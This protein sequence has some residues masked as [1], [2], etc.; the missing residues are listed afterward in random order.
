MIYAITTTYKDNFELLELFNYFYFNKWKFDYIFSLI[1]QTEKDISYLLKD[2]VYIK[3]LFY[4]KLEFKFYKE[5]NHF[6]VIYK[7]LNFTKSN[8]WNSF[9]KKIKNNI[10]NK[11]LQE[12]NKNFFNQYIDND[13]LY[14]FPDNF[15]IKEKILKNKISFHYLE[16]IPKDEFNINDDLLFS[17]Y[18]QSNRS[19][20]MNHTSC[21]TLYKEHFY[22]NNDRIISNNCKNILD[23]NKLDNKFLC[24][25]FSIISKNHFL[26]YRV[27]KYKSDNINKNIGLK[28]LN[29]DFNNKLFPPFCENGRKIF[30]LFNQEPEN[31]TD[32]NFY[33]VC[34][35]Y[36]EYIKNINNYKNYIKINIFKY[37]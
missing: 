16:Y 4:E 17:L 30:E 19:N 23:G 1:G 3:S 2:K 37:L 10:I 24:F 33:Q 14:Y 25:H 28:N 34:L 31:N 36:F 29:I 35:N 21:K 7:D 22:H 20:K 8:S 13:E 32:D 15:N 11:F 9:R 5:N 6:L 26:N 27:N 18:G 12:F